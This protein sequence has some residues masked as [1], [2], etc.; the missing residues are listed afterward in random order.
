MKQAHISNPTLPNRVMIDRCIDEHIQDIL[1]ISGRIGEIKSFF[2]REGLSH[3]S[4]I[5][6]DLVEDET[7][8]S[9][10]KPYLTR[11][12]LTA[13]TFLGGKLVVLGS[14]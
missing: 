9:Y 13:F 6:L 11:G 12:P 8:E 10:Q 7:G 14:N 3:Q 4:G 5:G 1:Y 2:S